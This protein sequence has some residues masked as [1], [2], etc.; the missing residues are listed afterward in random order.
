MT[1][2]FEF[3]RPPSWLKSFSCPAHFDLP[4][5]CVTTV[6]ILVRWRP[7]VQIQFVR[8]PGPLQHEIWF[9]GVSTSVWTGVIS[10]VLLFVVLWLVDSSL[11]QLWCLIYEWSPSL[12]VQTHH[13]FSAILFLFITCTPHSLG[14]KKRFLKKEQEF[15]CFWNFTGKNFNTFPETKRSQ[16]RRSRHRIRR[17]QPCSLKFCCDRRLK[18]PSPKENTSI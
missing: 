16:K 17:I 13:R 14:K 6:Q 11:L 2:Y 15:V 10:E 3:K 7:R 12:T 8:T 18:L 5:L 1:V 9:L 4:V